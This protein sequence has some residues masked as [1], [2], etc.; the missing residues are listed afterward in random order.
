MK[1]KT[2]IFYVRMVKAKSSGI[3]LEMEDLIHEFA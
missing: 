1:A 3:F 2:Y